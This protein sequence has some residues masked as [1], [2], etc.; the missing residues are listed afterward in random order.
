MCRCSGRF[1]CALVIV[2]LTGCGESRPAA[3]VSGKVTIKG[4]PASNLV[5]R[6]QPVGTGAS[7]KKDS[8]MG[9]F[10]RTGTDG[11]FDLRFSDDE[12]PGATPGEQVV[13][14]DEL[15]PPEEANNDAGGVGKKVVSRI[16][17]KWKNGTQRFTVKDG[18]NEANFELAP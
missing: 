11:Q 1:L 8:G 6:F 10:G 16:P 5:V 17:P 9:S 12:S 4:Q 15:T 13:I 14:I 3:R 18:T 2:A 7:V